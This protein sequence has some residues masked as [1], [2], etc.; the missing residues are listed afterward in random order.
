MQFIE[1]AKIA[2]S[3]AKSTTAASQKSNIALERVVTHQRKN[4][5]DFAALWLR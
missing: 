2:N 5:V 3:P 4:A 1:D